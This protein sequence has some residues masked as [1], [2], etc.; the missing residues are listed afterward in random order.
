[1]ESR[2]KELPQQR[3]PANPL[4]R[5][6][7]ARTGTHANCP[8]IGGSRTSEEWVIRMSRAFLISNEAGMDWDAKG[9]FSIDPD[10]TVTPCRY[11]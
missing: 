1:V 5:Y 11:R 7:T 9:A 8:S 10:L 4:G 6:L 3:G 2:P